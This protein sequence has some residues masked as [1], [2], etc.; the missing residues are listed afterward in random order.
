[1]KKI[2]N[3]CEENINELT[4]VSDKKES[5]TLDVV[6]V[7]DKSGSMTG[8]ERSVI[9]GFNA[10]VEKESCK[11]RDSRVTTVV[12]DH[13]YKKLYSRKD[14]NDVEILTD[15]DYY[16]SGCTA[17]YDAIGFTIQDLMAEV[18]NDV[19]FIIITDGYENSSK[20][21]NKERINSLIDELDWEFVFVGAEIDSYAEASKI[22]IKG[23]H[24]ANFSKS[25]ESFKEVFNA[26][27]EMTG[28]IHENK[29]IDDLDWKE[30][31]EG[32]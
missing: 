1:M 15:K 20:R 30:D 10:F 27:Y 31:I 7:L 3:I 14:I 26:C 5:K 19:L 8:S 13:D 28:C 6:F 9:N 18:D 4:V 17:L 11:D 12:F 24:T 2:E 16:P 32:N 21:F 22:G 29:C 23:S 25:E